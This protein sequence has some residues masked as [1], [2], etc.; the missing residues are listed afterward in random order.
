MYF[1][2]VLFVVS[3]LLIGQNHAEVKATVIVFRHGER[4]PVVTTEAVPNSVADKIGFG[5]LTRVF[6]PKITF[7]RTKSISHCIL[8]SLAA[9]NTTWMG[10]PCGHGIFTCSPMMATS[11]WATC[12]SWALTQTGPSWVYNHLCPDFSRR[13]CWIWL[14]PSTG[15]HSPS[16]LTTR[17]R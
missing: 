7:V 14:C 3:C 12:K 1:G 16:P 2:A 6:M 10:S 13:L 15:S 17:E 9:G 11:G 4:T 5:Q 8:L